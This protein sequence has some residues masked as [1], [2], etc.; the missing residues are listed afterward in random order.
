[1]IDELT[2]CEVCLENLDDEQFDYRFDTP[3]CLKCGL[4]IE[5]EGE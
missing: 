3:I 2:Y 4:H 5:L 1:M